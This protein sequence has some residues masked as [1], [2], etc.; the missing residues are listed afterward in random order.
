ML[1]Y[2]ADISSENMQALGLRQVRHHLSQLIAQ[3]HSTSGDL[4]A[5]FQQKQQDSDV[6]IVHNLSDIPH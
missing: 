5:H 6:S 2:L 4:L 1:I 3:E